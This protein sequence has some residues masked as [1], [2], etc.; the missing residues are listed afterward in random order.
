MLRPI[1]NTILFRV[2]MLFLILPVGVLDMVDAKA[3]NLS[4]NENLVN[5]D[6]KVDLSSPYIPKDEY[7]RIDYHKLVRLVSK[8]KFSELLS[9]RNIEHDIEYCDDRN[10]HVKTV[11]DITN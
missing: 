4:Q 7:G 8:P 11:E 2:T 1:M 3:A 5:K 10:I 6:G 9:Q